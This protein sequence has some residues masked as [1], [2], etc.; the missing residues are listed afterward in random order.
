M[1]MRRKKSPK[2]SPNLPT[3]EFKPNKPESS[4]LSTGEFKPNK[5]EPPSPPTK[6]FKPK[7]QSEE[8][9]PSQ[10]TVK[11]ESQTLV[12]PPPNLRNQ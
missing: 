3:R 11:K 1:N 9:F 6:E 5:P 4:N 12:N 8:E 10:L 2:V 7:Q